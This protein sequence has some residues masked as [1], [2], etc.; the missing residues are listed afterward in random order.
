VK[1][2]LTAEVNAIYKLE[3]GDESN[4]L[5]MQKAVTLDGEAVLVSRWELTD[6][7][8]EA[9]HNGAL[10]RL[11]VWGTALPPVALAV[12]GIELDAG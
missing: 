9:I 11:V 4:D 3:G 12:E 2:A 7:E 10:V 6:E 5:P 8:R 1:P